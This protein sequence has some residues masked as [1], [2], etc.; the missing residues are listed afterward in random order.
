MSTHRL[1]WCDGRCG[2]RRGRHWLRSFGTIMAV[3]AVP[4]QVVWS[5]TQALPTPLACASHP[6]RSLTSGCPPWMAG[7]HLE[8]PG[9]LLSMEIKRQ[10]PA[11]A[12]RR[13]GARAA[14]LVHA[15]GCVGARGGLRS[16]S[17]RPVVVEL[18]YSRSLAGPTGPNAEMGGLFRPWMCS[19]GSEPDVGPIRPI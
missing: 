8:M 1:R 13:A 16:R 17:G 14:R 9:D 15:L 12:W 6:Q 4:L 7:G 2:A 10:C 18:A 11:A 19:E 5:T 3:L